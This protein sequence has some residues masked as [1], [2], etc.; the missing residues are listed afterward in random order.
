MNKIAILHVPHGRKGD[1]RQ[2]EAI[3]ELGF[4]SFDETAEYLT[5]NALDYELEAGD[6][7]VMFD[8]DGDFTSTY[9]IETSVKLS[10]V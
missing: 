10:E 3:G 8:S 6:R 7:V 2:P 9:E 1:S 4:S 5:E